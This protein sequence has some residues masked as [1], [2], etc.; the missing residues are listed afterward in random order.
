MPDIMCERGNSD[1]NNP[2]VTYWHEFLG[3]SSEIF[4]T[5]D[6]SDQCFRESEIFIQTCFSHYMASWKAF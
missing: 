5:Y 4:E 2:L 3:V 6:I 1:L